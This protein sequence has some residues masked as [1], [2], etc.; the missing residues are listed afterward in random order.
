MVNPMVGETAHREPDGNLGRAER[1][2]LSS[3]DMMP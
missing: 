3:G 1:A 2:G